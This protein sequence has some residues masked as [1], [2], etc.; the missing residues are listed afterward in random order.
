[1]R[2]LIFGMPLIACMAI[3]SVSMQHSLTCNSQIEMASATPPQ[4]FRVLI[5][6][7]SPSNAATK[8]T[9]RNDLKRCDDFQQQV[10]RLKELVR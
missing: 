2:L 9:I 8:D 1:M 10:Q 7:R 5:A 6:H 4:L 3:M